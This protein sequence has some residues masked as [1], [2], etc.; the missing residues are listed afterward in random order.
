VSPTILI[1][2]D[3]ERIVRMLDRYFSGR[4]HTLVGTADPVGVERLIAE[5]HPDVLLLDWALP[6]RPGIEVLRQLRAQPRYAALPVIMLTARSEEMDKVEGLLT[7]AD[8]FV[9]K[10]FSLAELEARVTSVLRRAKRSPAAYLDERLAVD[11]AKRKLSVDR[12]PASLSA[13]EW[14]FLERLLGSQE[15]VSRPE[16]VTAVWGEGTEVSDRSID[17]IVMRLRRVLGDDPQTGEPYIVTERGFGYRFAR[18][19]T[20]SA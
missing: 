4:G 19:R 17:N 9:S 8:D 1:I 10:P 3:D 7:G 6:G 16:L 14:S 20:P 18:R 11:P 15:G 13:T 12:K 2:E 5:V